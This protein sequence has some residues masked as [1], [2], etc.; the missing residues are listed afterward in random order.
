MVDGNYLDPPQSWYSLKYSTKTTECTFQLKIISTYRLLHDIQTKWD[1]HYVLIKILEWQILVMGCINKRTSGMS[2]GMPG[3]LSQLGDQL[4]ILA[5]VMISGLRWNPSFSLCWVG[6]LLKILSL[7]TPFSFHCMCALSK[8]GNSF[9]KM[10]V[11][12]YSLQNRYL[13]KPSIEK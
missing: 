10:A 1:I 9:K 6:R 3:W 13:F 4:M 7:C 8:K 5:Q 2:F 12:N 11:H